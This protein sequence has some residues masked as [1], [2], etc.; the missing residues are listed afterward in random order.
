MK[1]D[2]ILSEAGKKK[3]RRRVGRGHGSGHGKTSGRGHKGAGQRAGTTGRLGFEG[4]TNPA[5]ARIPQRGFNNANFRTEFDVVNICVL[6]RFEDGATVNAEVLAAANLITDADSLIKIL[7]NGELS[8]KLTVVAN[9]FSA[10]AVEKITK[11]GGTT[12][13]VK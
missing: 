7:G 5:L 4:G 6:D 10:S 1:L 13:T 8:K 12:E 2:D 11:A 3:A 9:K